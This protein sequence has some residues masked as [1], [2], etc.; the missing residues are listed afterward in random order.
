MEIIFCV[1]YLLLFFLL[2]DY[3]SKKSTYIRYLIIAMILSIIIGCIC[4]AV[5]A[6]AK[7]SELPHFVFWSVPIICLMKLEKALRKDR[8]QKESGKTEDGSLVDE[9]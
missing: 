8:H 9:N 6:T 5:F 2:S 7:T 1:L 4:M 3:F